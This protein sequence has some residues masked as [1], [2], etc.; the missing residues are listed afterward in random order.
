MDDSNNFFA[1][2]KKEVGD[3]L[4]NRILLI[5]LQAAS[6]SSGLIAKLSIVLILGLLGF[7][8]LFFLSIVGGYFFADITGS[9]YIGYGII[10]LIYILCFV[11]VYSR[12]QK[13]VNTIRNL[14]IKVLFD[15]DDQQ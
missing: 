1:D 13:M 7:C 2:T 3:Y 9:L 6:K 12:R 4:E 15:K 8:V 11:I 14:I 5:K 10:T